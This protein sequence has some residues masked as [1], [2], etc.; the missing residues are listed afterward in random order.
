MQT[1]EMGNYIV[2]KRPKL[3]GID[4]S[5]RADRHLINANVPSSTGCD[6]GIERLGREVVIGQVRFVAHAVEFHAL[7]RNAQPT[8]GGK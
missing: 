3:D 1:G 6:V 4:P 2:S 7:I 8:S 5:C